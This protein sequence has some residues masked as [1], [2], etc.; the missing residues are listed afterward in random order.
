MKADS[1]PLVRTATPDDISAIFSIRISVT[2]NHLD[3]N[4]LARRGVTPESMAE[5]FASTDSRTWVVEGPEG[6]RE[7]STADLKS[8]S[9]FAVFVSPAAEGRGYGRALLEA[10]ETWLFAGGWDTIS[11][12]T[13]EEPGNRAHAFYRAAGWESAGPADHGDVRYE[14]SCTR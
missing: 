14:K 12:Q 10:A 4:Q 8:G 11:L 9:I 3:L 13:A 5:A 2:E 6:I 1:R 7:F